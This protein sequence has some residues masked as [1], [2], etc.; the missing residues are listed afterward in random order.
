[1]LRAAILPLQWMTR[2]LSVAALIS[3][4]NLVAGPSTTA[5]AS[6][7]A[8]TVT[9]VPKGDLGLVLSDPD[10]WTL[11]TWDGDMEGVSNCYDACAAAWPPYTITGD[12]IA[13]DDLPGSLGLIERDDGSWQVTIDNWPLYYFAFD[14]QPG[15]VNG[16]GNMG[17]GAQ[18]Y[19]MAY[20]P[21][22][23][24]EPTV[25]TVP[26]PVVPS[27]PAPAQP[28]PPVA[29][30]PPVV[31]MPA[32]T[33]TPTRQTVQVSIVDFDFRPPTV[34]IQVGDTVTWT[35]NGRAVHT[36]TSDTIGFDSGRLNPGQGFSHTF[37]APGTFPYHCALHPNMH[38]TIVVGSGGAPV[39]GQQGPL[40]FPPN[41]GPPAV[42][43]G[44]FYGTPPYPGG[45]PF[46]YDTNPYDNYP[47]IPYPP[48]P[49]QAGLAPSQVLSVIVP[50]NGTIALSWPTVPNIASYRIY[51]APASTQNNWS[52]VSTVNSSPGTPV[53]QTTVTGLTPG[54]IYNF[55]VRAL[56][57]NGIETVIPSASPQ[58]GPP[59][60]TQPAEPLS[61]TGTTS[62]SVTLG[63]TPLPG[64]TSYRVVQ[65]SSPSGPFIL[66]SAGTVPTTSATV[67]G[68]SPNTTYYFQ[69]VPLDQV[70]NQGPPTNTVS[71]NT[72]GSL[73]AP[74]G[75]AVITATGSS[76]T[77]SWGASPG[78]VTYRVLQSQLP[79]GPF[80]PINPAALTTTGATITGLTPNTTYYY[81]VVAL[82]AAGNQS[83]PS[84]TLIV[85]TGAP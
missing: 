7:P 54:A 77:L 14:N 85:T 15:D 19:A 65:S 21:P 13:P 31:A 1:M 30:A 41:L 18:W 6:Q 70:G 26:V 38:G 35:N 68:L 42:D 10:G 52:L 45:Q 4:L 59:I 9:L 46:P 25:V 76:V 40:P 61:V 57:A 16:N 62:N 27:Q 82:D 43:T 83:P 75:L 20:S 78:A 66:S 67:T 8:P 32:A 24:P 28:A 84:N 72:S 47:P 74:A 34:N 11:Y 73:P 48:A 2:L 71:A 22:A 23:P 12:L 37:D 33:P 60:P 39:A 5:S 49:I 63:W 69:V 56:D 3:S 53:D 51:E 36:V 50:P 79:A 58:A 44:P 64:A 55:Q 81:Q 80:T 17:F 29:T